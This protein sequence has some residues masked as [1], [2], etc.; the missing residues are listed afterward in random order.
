MKKT[1][2]NAPVTKMPKNTPARLSQTC[3][4]TTKLFALVASI[5]R[6]NVR[7]TFNK[8]SYD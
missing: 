1:K 2:K 4:M 8:Q 6:T 5:A 3:M 7:W